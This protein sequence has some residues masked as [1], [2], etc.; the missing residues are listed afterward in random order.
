MSTVTAREAS[1]KLGV[2]GAKT[3]ALVHAA[4]RERVIDLPSC[5]R[6]RV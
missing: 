6:V 5:T 2:R 3:A 4:L 1:E